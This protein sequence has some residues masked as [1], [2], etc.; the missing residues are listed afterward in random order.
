MEALRALRIHRDS[1]ENPLDFEIEVGLSLEKEIIAGLTLGSILG[2]LPWPKCLNRV[3]P[4]IGMIGLIL[5][6][7]NLE[8]KICH[9]K[10]CKVWVVSVGCILSA[11]N[12]SL[13]VMIV[14][15]IFLA[16]WMD[17]GSIL[18][19]LRLWVMKAWLEVCFLGTI[20]LSNRFGAM[21]LDILDKVLKS[22]ASANFSYE[23]KK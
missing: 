3:V 20:T 16:K 6:A 11:L 21:N 19:D 18:G 23:H 2:R 17:W 1:H 10:N 15:I 5:M 14:L 8:Y 12:S 22:Y 9:T 4:T 7:A 13:S